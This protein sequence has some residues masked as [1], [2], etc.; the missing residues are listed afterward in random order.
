MKLL[1][2]LVEA[3]MDSHVEAARLAHSGVLHGA[4]LHLLEGP[5]V[6]EVPGVDRELLV[7]TVVYLMGDHCVELALIGIAL[8]VLVAF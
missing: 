6:L 3:L 5:L 8:Y 7:I 2:L 1:L 4:V